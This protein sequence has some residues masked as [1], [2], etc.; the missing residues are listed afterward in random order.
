MCNIKFSP[1]FNKGLQ[2]IKPN[3]QFSPWYAAYMLWMLLQKEIVK[4]EQFKEVRER[5]ERWL[6]LLLCI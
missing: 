4:V 2:K 5:A 1:Y 6:G 3:I